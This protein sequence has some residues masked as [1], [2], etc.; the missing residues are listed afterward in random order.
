[1]KENHEREKFFVCLIFIKG[2]IF[3]DSLV[4]KELQGKKLKNEREKICLFKQIAPEASS[5]GISEGIACNFVF[6]LVKNWCLLVNNWFLWERAEF[7][8]S[9]CFFTV[10]DSVEICGPMMTVAVHGTIP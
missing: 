8:S 5:H 6:L 7:H 1:M 10:S 2:C 4:N 3:R 9:K